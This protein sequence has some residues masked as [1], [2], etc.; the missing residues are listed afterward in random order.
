MG[1]PMIDLSNATKGIGWG[2]DD[3]CLECG[4]YIG[5]R[6]CITCKARD[7]GASDTAF[8]LFLTRDRNGKLVDAEWAW[9]H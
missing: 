3:H 6:V 8:E 7:L 1:H 4:N 9:V 5:M 2:E